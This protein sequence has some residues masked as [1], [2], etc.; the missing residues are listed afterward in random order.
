MPAAASVLRALLAV[1]GVFFAAV[2]VAVG[3]FAFTGDGLPAMLALGFS[4]LAAAAGGATLTTALSASTGLGPAQASALKFASVFALAAL[5][6][7]VVGQVADPS[8]LA[9]WF[10]FGGAVGTALRMFV[11]AL[12]ALVVGLAIAVRL[13]GD[14]ATDLLTP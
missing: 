7:P 6:V 11:L 2:G 4:V 1:V 10:G 14:D 12:A 5:A 13:L 9:S 3:A 8:L